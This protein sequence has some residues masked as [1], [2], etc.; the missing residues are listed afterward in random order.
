[1]FELSQS[2]FDYIAG[3]NALG[4]WP[5][6]HARP[7]KHHASPFCASMVDASGIAFL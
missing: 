2:L 7:G 5:R 6:T 1:M 4:E 3:A